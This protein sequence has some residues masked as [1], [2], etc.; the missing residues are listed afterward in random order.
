[1]CFP[2]VCTYPS[3]KRRRGLGTLSREKSLTTPGDGCRG[4][5][6][7]VLSDQDFK[8][9]FEEMLHKLVTDAKLFRHSKLTTRAS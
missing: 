1:M 7:P 6:G 3:V 4:G 2:D 5:V 8:D 9:G